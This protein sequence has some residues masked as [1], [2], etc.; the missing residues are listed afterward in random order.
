MS[1]RERGMG[2]GI[3][4]E[5]FRRQ[6]ARVSKEGET[7]SPPF[8]TCIFQFARGGCAPAVALGLLGWD[9]ASLA[10][11]D[12]LLRVSILLRCAQVCLPVKKL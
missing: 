11:V 6:V 4:A 8:H 1:V 9:G 12:F 10:R 5:C 2:G 3:W 7:F